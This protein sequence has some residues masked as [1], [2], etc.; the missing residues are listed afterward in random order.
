M[1]VEDRNIQ[2]VLIKSE[3]GAG[4]YGASLGIEAIKFAAMK[5]DS[6]IFRSLPTTYVDCPDIYLYAP[7]RS[8]HARSIELIL[9]LYYKISDSI[10]DSLVCGN[11]P[12]II[13]GDHANAGGTI[14]GIRK[15]Y[16][17]KKLGVIWIDAHADIHSPYTTP[18]GNIHGMPLAA[19]LNLQLENPLY[20]QPDLQTK[21]SWSRLCNIGDVAPK[22]EARDLVLIGIRELEEPEWEIIRRLNI[23]YYNPEQIN[24]LGAATVATEALEY[25]S[26]CDVLYVSFDIDSMDASLVPGT[27]TP[28]ANGLNFEQTA[29]ILNT[30]WQSERLAAIEFTEINPLLDIR[31]QTAE[32]AFRLISNLIKYD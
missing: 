31:N 25:L 26:G 27:G 10:E 16:P 30:L 18:S 21:R 8:P 1:G 17:D 13:S 5:A 32:I 15:A 20:N 23:K 3:L 28:V 19:S 24:T 14:A 6:E 29:T 22:I 4:T 9:K 7:E 12:F 11:F 2:L